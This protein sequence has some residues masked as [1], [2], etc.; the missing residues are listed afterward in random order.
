MLTTKNFL[1]YIENQ[2]NLNTKGKTF[3]L[4][5]KVGLYQEAYRQLNS[6]I[7]YVFGIFSLAPSQ[8]V[9]VKNLDIATITARLEIEVDIDRVAPTLESSGKPK[10]FPEVE[11]ICDIWDNFAQSHNGETLTLSDGTNNYAVT[12]V[13][14][15]ASQGLVEMTTS[16]TGEILPLN[17]QMEFTIVQ[18]GVCA[19]DVELT[20]DGEE[21]FFTGLTFTRHRTADTIQRVGDDA[22]KSAILQNGA[23]IDFTTPLL[24]ASR[25]S[26]KYS[27]DLLKGGQNNAYCVVYKRNGGTGAYIMTLGTQTESATPPSFVGEN[28]SF[29]EV[30]PELATYNTT[31]DDKVWLTQTIT[32]STSFVG[33]LTLTNCDVGTCVFWG[34]NTSSVLTTG[35]ASQ[36]L[37]H[38]YPNA[39]SRLV[40]VFKIKLV[41]DDE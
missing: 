32:P 27:D 10:S 1:T 36:T 38:T 9:P 39:D 37:T 14:T 24:G 6:E 20:V 16:D 30:I 25:F 13:Y 29:V 18:N 15:L 5:D 8:L 23:G 21:L 41:A 4:F 7:S 12:C 40:R 2:L 31:G 3:R 28:V 26:Y 17:M 35:S 22:T 33:S 19:N 11:T 34:D